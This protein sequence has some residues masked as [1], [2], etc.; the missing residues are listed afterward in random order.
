MNKI[1]DNVE[2]STNTAKFIKFAIKSC[3]LPLDISKERKLFKFTSW[4]CF[5][6]IGIYILGI[7]ILDYSVEEIGIQVFSIFLI[8]LQKLIFS[9]FGGSIGKCILASNFIEA[10]SC[11]V[12]VMFDIIYRFFPL[13]LSYGLQSFDPEKLCKND[14]K[15]PKQG[16]PIIFGK[17]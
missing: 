12:G 8:I 17:F 11:I 15:W 16:Y 1:K 4:K 7:A 13:I 10:V 2:K 9:V 3:L 6:H 5:I 14:L